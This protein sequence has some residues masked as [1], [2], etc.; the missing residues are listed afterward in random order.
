MDYALLNSIFGKLI[1]ADDYLQT[2][3]R[4]TLK[5]FCRSCFQPATVVAQSIS[6]SAA[7]FKSTHLPNCEEANLNFS[8][9]GSASRTNAN[10]SNDIQVRLD[11]PRLQQYGTRSVSES[12]TEKS[13]IKTRKIGSLRNLGYSLFASSTLAN[14]DSTITVIFDTQELTGSIRQVCLPTASLTT[15][16][17]KQKSTGE[18]HRIF[19]GHFEPLSPFDNGRHGLFFSSSIFKFFLRHDIRPQIRGLN[20]KA[21]AFIIFGEAKPN[22]SPK[23]PDSFLIK[24]SNERSI[25]F[26]R[27]P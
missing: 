18:N 7:H 26:L 20:S 23:Y 21:N 10:P 11:P 8:G 2:S 16:G 4:R 25:V 24:V 1:S 17:F 9:S 13:E 19:Y 6:G 14:S 5:C 22:P 12:S 15:S 27:V 3:P